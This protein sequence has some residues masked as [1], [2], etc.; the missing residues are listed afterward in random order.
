MAELA[1]PRPVEDGSWW[2]RPCGGREVLQLAL[3][4][5]IST[6]SWTIMNF[7]DRMF[8]MWY[9]PAAMAA[10]LPA[11][12]L[13]FAVLCFP[14]GIASYANTF[15]AQYNGAGRPDRIGQVVFQAS[16]FSLAMIPLILATNPLAPVVFQLSG[17]GP[18]LVELESVYY[19]T[20]SWGAG[21]VIL[22][23]ALSTYFTGRGLTKTVMIVDSF[24]AGLNI[25]LDYAWVFGVWGFPEKGIEGAAW[26]TVVA[27]WV[28]CAIYLWLILYGRDR[29]LCGVRS[30]MKFDGDLFRRLMRFGA[31]AGLQML[32]EVSAFTLFILMVGQ[33]GEEA[34]STSTMAFNVNSVAF[35]PIL[36]LGIAIATMVGNQLGQDQPDL[37]ARAVWTSFVIALAYS[38]VMAVLYLGAPDLFL[39]GHA[40]NSNPAEFARL[41]DVTVVLLRFVAAYCLFDAMNIVFVSAI[42]GAGDTRFVVG[43]S[44]FTSPIP[45]LAGWVGVHY[46]GAGLIWCWWVIT[47]WIMALGI[48]YWL[49]FLQGKWRTMRVIE[50]HLEGQEVLDAA[51]RT[52][53]EPLA[54]AA[55]HLATHKTDDD[56]EAADEGLQTEALRKRAGSVIDRS[57]EQTGSGH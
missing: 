50:T 28:K 36:G 30:G 46:F 44:L 21:G 37:A 51:A 19:Q 45:V 17:H 1:A 6:L 32:I 12:M 3:P 53:C 57:P 39:M 10:S 16:V 15:V 18:A 22:A 23:A 43:T 9:S 33:L 48:I 31:P 13:H 26:A 8:L 7:T 54:E 56:G 29:A 42:K 14:L 2:S 41:R 27:L 20:L 40:A 38:A 35:L 49:R 4:L 55:L 52:G 34:L 11:S 5:V 24:V 25:V 47:G